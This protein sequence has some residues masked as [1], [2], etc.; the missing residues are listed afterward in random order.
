VCE[1]KDKEIR[2]FNKPYQLK[3]F[4]LDSNY[5][6]GYCQIRISA[7]QGS[8]TYQTTV[9]AQVRISTPVLVARQTIARGEPFSNCN[10][11]LKRVDI[12]NYADKCYDSLS[13]LDGRRAMRTIS[14]GMVIHERMI[15]SIPAIE[16][17]E[18]VELSVSDGPV[19]ASIAGLARENG[20]IGDKIWVENQQSRQL[21]RALVIG[22]GQVK[23]LNRRGTI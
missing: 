17:G 8:R 15:A 23:I 10:C 12:T 20:S 6:K 16:R 11:E 2:C 14:A 22:K 18:Q 7:T 21:V 9:L 19:T 13:Q 1:E 4:G 3:V 5:P